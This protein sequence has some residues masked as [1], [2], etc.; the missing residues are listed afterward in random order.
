[1][2]NLI[3]YSKYARNEYSQF[4]EDGIIEYIISK[5]PDKDKWCVEFG[6]WDGIYLS[7]TF[8]LVKNHG[9]RPVLIEADKKKFQVLQANMASFEAVLLNKFVSFDGANTLDKILEKIGIPIDFDLL[10]ID[11]DGNDYWIFD[12]I[13]EFRP[14]IICI[15]YNPS[16]PNSVEYIQPRNFL[17]KR[18]C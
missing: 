11:I 9:Y 6:A 5:L 17:V 10:S 4:G 18:G 7:N 8:N 1:M 16:I 3:D 12:S 14:K 2:S 13:V 15:E